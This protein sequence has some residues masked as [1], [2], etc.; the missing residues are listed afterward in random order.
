MRLCTPTRA[1]KVVVGL[2]LVVLIAQTI[3][4]VCW[5]LYDISI[6]DDIYTV[7]FY[8][9]LP[10]AVLII[11][12]IVVREVRRRASSDAA[13]NLG[14][15]HQQ[16]TS[17]TSAV[18]TVMLVTT[19]VIYVL[20]NGAWSMCYLAFRFLFQYYAIS[21]AALLFIYAYNFYV[22]LI[23][24]KQ[25][26][27]DLLTLVCCCCRSCSSSCPSCSSCSSSSSSSSAAADAAAGADVR[28]AT[29]GYAETVV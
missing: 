20:L 28:V 7:V 4:H 5:Y 15:Q 14:L 3:N 16:S 10:L 26:R 18:P 11:N 25:F 12:A 1:K 13:S 9:V 6:V 19:S 2:P 23:T 27:A 8:M 24:G 21:S 22:Y 17:S 29:R